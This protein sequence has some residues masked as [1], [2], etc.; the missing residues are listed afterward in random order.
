MGQLATRDMDESEFIRTAEITLQ[1][2]DRR[3]EAS[4]VD[5]DCEFK[6]TGVLEIEFADGSKII[7]NSQAAAREIWVA[8]KS[9]GYHF[10]GEAGRW[11]NTRDGTELFAALSLYASQQAGEPVD[12]RQGLP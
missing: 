8:A 7:V 10:R 2:L 5:A 9:G 11:L 6:G 12:L 1:E 3:I 4:G